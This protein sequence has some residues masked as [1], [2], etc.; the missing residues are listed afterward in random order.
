MRFAVLADAHIGRSIPLAIAEHR[1]R[2][3]STAFTKAVDAIVEAGVDYVFICGDLF[4]RRTLRPYLVQFTHD[5][6]YRLSTETEERH[7]KP[8]KILIIRGNH[9]GRSQSDTL[10]YI[11][12]PLADYLHVFE[13][14]NITYKDENLH[15]VGLN[16]YDQ[17]DRAFD[18]LVVPAFQ[19]AEG[20]RILMLHGFVQGYNQVPPYESSVTLDQLASVE[21]AFVFTGHYHRRCPRRRL[22]NG[23]W[24]LTPGSLEMYD[25]AETPEKGFYIVDANG[26]EPQ[27]TWVPIEPM[28][29]MKQVRVVS[30]HSREPQW[31]RDRVVEKV[32]AFREE[33]VGAG[34]EG[35]I[36]VRVQGG[37]RNGYPGDIDLSPVDEMVSSDPLLLW[38]DV[39]TLGIEMPLLAGV[40]ERE[41]VDV[42]AFFSAMGE[43]ADDI[44]EMHGRIRETL[45]E[46][47]SLQTGLLTPSQRIPL[48]KEWVERF[49]KRSF[50]EDEP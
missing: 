24:A 42:R 9:D 48:V 23:G 20:T 36:R 30:D 3:F 18:Q 43:F 47:A 32:E 10:D 5:E 6:L 1:R 13:D 2:A 7:G 37:L 12:H 11:K 19:G 40:P 8:T 39:D 35:Y 50:G 33:L 14:D 17:V 45:E 27:F 15:V 26:E 49:E 16:Y 29:A 34:K 21:P 46:E 41:L 31:Y 4:E 38:V 25:F 44:G 22:P 28:H